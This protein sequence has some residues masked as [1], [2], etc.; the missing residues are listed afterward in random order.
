MAPKVIK[1]P[2]RY[3]KNFPAAQAFTDNIVDDMHVMPRNYW[4]GHGKDTH[5]PEELFVYDL[6]CEATITEVHLRNSHNG[7]KNNR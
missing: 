1:D 3:N 5:A 4:V 6:G 7:H 2:H